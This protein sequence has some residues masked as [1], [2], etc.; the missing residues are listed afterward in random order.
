MTGQPRL[1]A[2]AVEARLNHLLDRAR[3]GVLLPAEGEALAGMV[4]ELEAKVTE[5]EHTINWH[6]TC[7][8]CARILDSA[9]AET[10]R[11]ET[12]EAEVARLTA[13]Q[14]TCSRRMC[15]LHHTVPVAGCPY[16]K[17]I[18]ARATT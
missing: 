7:T 18:K 15:D 9:Y 10:V 12:A 5:Y 14:C 1:P 6:T 11:A 8:S 17:C 4:G 3:R 2:D 13:G 16:P